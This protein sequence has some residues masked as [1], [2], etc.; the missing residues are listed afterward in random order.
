MGM[1][2]VTIGLIAASVVAAGATVYSSNREASAAKHAANKTAEI[3]T[4]RIKAQ[5]ESEKTA[6]ETAKHKLK[7]KQASQ[8]N[9]ILN[10]PVT[11]LVEDNNTNTKGILGV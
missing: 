4:A 1:D 2:P 11:G 8:S 6:A 9:N 5:E 3:E 10:A 7:L